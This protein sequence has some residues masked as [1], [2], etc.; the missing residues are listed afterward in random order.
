MSGVGSTMPK[1]S[2]MVS[3][4]ISMHASSLQDF[5]FISGKIDSL[6]GMSMKDLMKSINTI[7]L[8]LY[9]NTNNVQV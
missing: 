2:A 6:F 3:D 1:G 4:R 8:Q 5:S 9:H 7:V